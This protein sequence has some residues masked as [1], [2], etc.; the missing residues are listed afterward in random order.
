MKDDLLVLLVDDKE[1]EFRTLEQTLH[2]AG[3]RTQRVH[4]C[5]EARAALREPRPSRLILT[6]TA[7]ADGT[8][9]D[10]LNLASMH[11]RA[12]PV[13]VVSRFVD[14]GLYLKTLE[15]GASDFIVPP[16][17]ADDLAYLVHTAIAKN[18]I[19]MTLL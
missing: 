4:T 7:L 11:G 2:S 9:A 19:S 1:G 18:S 17:S 12:V 5:S 14:V 6:A 15:S 3:I 10:V 8:W 16:F 13:I